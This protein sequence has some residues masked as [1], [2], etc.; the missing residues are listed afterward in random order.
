M[1]IYCTTQGALLGALW[2][3]K[4]EGIPKGRGDVY[5][6]LIHFEVQQK[7]A[8]HCKATFVKCNKMK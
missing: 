4:R 3:S 2:G 8:G 7:I 1:K 5:A 6:E